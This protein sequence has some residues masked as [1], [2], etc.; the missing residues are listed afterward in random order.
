MPHNRSIGGR[1]AIVT[2][3]AGSVIAMEERSSLAV[4]ITVAIDGIA[5]TVAMTTGAATGTEAATATDTP[6]MLEASA[7]SR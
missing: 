3:D 6:A 2:E 1:T 7:L 5:G 4:I